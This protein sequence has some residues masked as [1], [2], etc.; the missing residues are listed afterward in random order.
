MMEVNAKSKPA[1][2]R[3]EDRRQKQRL[4]YLIDGID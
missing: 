1:S 3:N 2:K 4:H